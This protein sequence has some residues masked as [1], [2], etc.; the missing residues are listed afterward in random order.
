M[1]ALGDEGRRRPVG[2]LGVEVGGDGDGGVRG[3]NV[4]V[5]A[6]DEKQRRLAGEI[7]SGKLNGHGAGF[8]GS[9]RDV[10]I[11]IEDG[12]DAFAGLFLMQLQMCHKRD[13][14]RGV[15]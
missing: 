4:D 13:G 15:E 7:F 10:V 9:E 8:A 1:G 3:E 6:I 5:E 12:E 14:G 11:R 2:G